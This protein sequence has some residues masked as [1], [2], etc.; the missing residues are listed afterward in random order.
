MDMPTIGVEEWLNVWERSTTTDIAQST[1]ASLTMA[2]LRALDGADGA[3]FYELL[4]RETMNYG[5]IEGS[6]AFKREVKGLYRTEVDPADILQTNGC[7][8][9]NLNALMAL[10][11]PGD[12]VI[13]EWPTYAPLY[14]I[15]RALGAEVE[16]WRIKEELDWN[17]DIK[18]LERLIRP[19]TRLICINNASNPIGT[20]LS[21]DTLH[22]LAEI[23]ASVGAY[24]LCDEVYQPMDGEAE[25]ES[26]VDAYE[27]GIATN[28]VSKTYS[29]PGA[30]CG[31]VIAPREVSDRIRV[32]RDYTMICCGA[33]SDALG[34]YVLRHRDAILARNRNILLRNRELAQRWIDA[35]PRVS[36]VAPKGVSTAFVRLDIPE[37][38]EAFC[39]RLLERR[40]VLL[41][42]GSRFELPCGA[43]LGY[44]AQTEVLRR[45]LTLFGEELAELDR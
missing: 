43:R 31:W 44:C 24:V 2:E 33:F 7:T 4:D 30:R 45:G 42:P 9:A 16:Y 25:Y 36:W 15:P 37:K 3:E 12:H 26:I 39:R 28:S 14:E 5:W 38:D 19:D 10:V 1:I 32:C 22:Q 29:T 34:T 35:Q 23:A 13:A 17:P 21:A 27:R 41:V 8:G 40:G 11:S 18:D 6:P 20:I